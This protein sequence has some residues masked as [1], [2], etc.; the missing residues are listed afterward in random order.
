MTRRADRSDAQLDLFAAPA[1]SA[2]PPPP[3]PPTST[4]PELLALAAAL[5]AHVR[6]G[7]SSWTF[8]GWA[9]LVYRRRYATPAAFTRDSLAEYAEHPLFHT[10][11]IDRGY[12]A[13]IPAADLAAYAAQLPRGFLAVSKVFSELTTIT[14]PDHPRLGA[15]AGQPNPHFLDP[16]LFDELIAA[17]YAAEFAAHA[18]PF[19]IEIPPAP[20]RADPVALVA[21]LAAFFERAPQTFRYAVELRD[22]A[23]LTRRYLDVLRDHGAAHVLNQWSRMPTLGEQLRLPGVLTTDFCVAR[24]L[25]P[26]NTRYAQ[27]KEAFAPFDA[28]VAPQP[29]MRDAVR[30]LIEQT[31]ERM[32]ET[33]VIV[34]NK[35][36]GSSPLTIRAIAEELSAAPAVRYVPRR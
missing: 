27:L 4:D 1:R 28:L 30:R 11:G 19:V 24:L 29:E 36:E 22:R 3:A 17:P 15:R 14:F 20:G 12:Y 32:I 16:V 7:T 26:P 5:P 35:A 10:V 31:G 33:Y 34:N 25:L 23:L 8:P 6:F 13:P 18:G 2:P 9:G 21:R